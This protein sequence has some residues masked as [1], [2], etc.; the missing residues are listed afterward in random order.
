MDRS[1][2]RVSAVQ[3]LESSKRHTVWPGAP[4]LEPESIAAES[5]QRLTS[6]FDTEGRAARVRSF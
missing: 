4:W 2:Y 5:N 1:W 6:V 3:D